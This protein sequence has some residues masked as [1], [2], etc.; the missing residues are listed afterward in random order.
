LIHSN[1][2]II[3][4][5]A[6]AS[7]LDEVKQFAIDICGEIDKTGNTNML[8]VNGNIKAEAK[9]IITRIVGG[10][11]VSGDI[12]STTEAYENVLRKDLGADL[13]DIRKCKK[14]MA[15]MAFD[16]VCKKER[17]VKTP[18]LPQLIP[19]SYDFLDQN[20]YYH[21][22]PTST[23]PRNCSGDCD[24]KAREICEN[25]G[26]KIAAKYTKR[27]ENSPTDICIDEVWCTDGSKL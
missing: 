10:A 22:P 18:V 3:P 27:D 17:K 19:L 5:F 16:E 9:G 23:S 25:F 7:C 8:D 4:V 13:I 20:G 26:F 24:R 11:S 2:W 21:R 12:K 6:E 14:E 15:K 1:Q